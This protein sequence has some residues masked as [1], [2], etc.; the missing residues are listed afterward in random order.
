MQNNVLM[1][2]ND[3]LMWHLLH[4]AVLAHAQL[5]LCN[6]NTWLPSTAY[7]HRALLKYMH[8]VR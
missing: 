2:G 7:T 5:V 1:T 4:Q 6:S 8:T 3:T